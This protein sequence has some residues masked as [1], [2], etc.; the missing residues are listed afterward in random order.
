ML[1]SFPVDARLGPAHRDLMR[2]ERE[3]LCRVQ[4]D[5]AVDCGKFERLSSGIEPALGEQLGKCL[6]D[7]AGEIAL[8]VVVGAV[9]A[10]LYICSL[11]VVFEMVAIVPA[12]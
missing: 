12:V 3:R 9:D 1:P 8:D 6:D 4:L 10:P 7:R 5:L 2:W 11:R